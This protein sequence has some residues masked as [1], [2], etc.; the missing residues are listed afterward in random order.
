MPRVE[1]V[2]QERVIALSEAGLVLVESR[3]DP[4]E[5]HL[6]GPRGCTCKGYQYRAACRHQ[7]A[8]EALLA[9]TAPEGNR[10]PAPAPAAP[11]P[12]YTGPAC[13]ACGDRCPTVGQIHAGM[14]VNCSLF[15][16]PA[17]GGRRSA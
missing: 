15:G 13:A 8:A 4:D 11:P 7:K 16:P 5:W 2:G 17:S 10:T 12:A 9:R 6:V 14:C 3:S 1:L